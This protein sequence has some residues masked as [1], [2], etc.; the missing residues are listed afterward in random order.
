M[1]TSAHYKNQNIHLRKRPALRIGRCSG[2]GGGGQVHF[3]A[4]LPVTTTA[5][6]ALT[7]ATAQFT[8]L[9]LLYTSALTNYKK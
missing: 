4:L 3:S 5:Q 6:D 7:T 9:N 2:V 1:Y 8:R